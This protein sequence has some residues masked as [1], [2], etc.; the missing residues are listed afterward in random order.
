VSGRRSIDDL[1][2]WARSRI[3]RYEPAE[4]HAALSR[5]AVLVD[6][7]SAEDRTRDGVVPGSVWYP[8]SVLEWRLD[9]GSPTR[10]PDAPP[11]DAEVIL[12]CAHGYSSSLAAATLVHLGFAR[13]GDVVG[14]FDAW[15]AAGLPVE[16]A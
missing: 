10:A 13:A 3:A 9:P 5:G 15:A 1:L 6:T 7:R 2:A 14:G 4:A 11:L 12:V 16:R 8:R